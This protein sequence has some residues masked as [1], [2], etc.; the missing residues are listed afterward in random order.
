VLWPSDM[1]H[2]LHKYQW[3]DGDRPGIEAINPIA[4]THDGPH[5]AFVARYG[6][7][8][9]DRARLEAR[10]AANPPADPRA[11]SQALGLA[12]ID[13]LNE[14]TSKPVVRFR[15]E[16]PELVLLD[17]PSPDTTATRR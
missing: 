16:V 17:K 10:M 2:R 5:A 4:L 12:I 8:P 7:D 11:F 15:P 13:E 3:L 1:V 6:F 9:A 14:H